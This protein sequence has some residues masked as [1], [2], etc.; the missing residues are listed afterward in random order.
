[1]ETDKI[2]EIILI[3]I[4]FVVLA[5]NAYFGYEY[6]LAE[7]NTAGISEIFLANT[8][9]MSFQKIFIE[10]VLKSGGEVS[11]KDRLDL[12]S[13]AQNTNNQ[14]IVNAWHSFLAS[15]TEEQ[16]QARVLYLLSLFS[17]SL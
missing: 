17:G 5:C 13:F 14:D 15:K 11:Y 2:G 8:K 9:I 3:A 12:E 7:K 6:F 1:M 16:A 4:L 10:K